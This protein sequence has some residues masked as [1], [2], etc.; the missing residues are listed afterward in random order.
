MNS[1]IIKYLRVEALVF[2]LLSVF[3]YYQSGF[4]W[5]MFG[6]LILA[7]DVSWVGYLFGSRCG[8]VIYNIF[9]SYAIP[10]VTGMLGYSTKNELLLAIALIWATHISFDRLMGYGL[11]HASDFRDTHL[12]RIGKS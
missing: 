10:V 6:V 1:T 3:A 9:H 7:P 12:G 2:L 5:L 8:A 4:S 11:K